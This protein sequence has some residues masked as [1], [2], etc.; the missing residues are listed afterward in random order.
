M[1]VTGAGWRLE[2]LHLPGH[3]ADHLGFALDR[4][5][6]CGDLVMGWSTS[7]ISPPDGDLAAFMA[8]LDRLKTRDWQVLLPGHGAPVD[9]PSDRIQALI[10][11]RQARADAVHAALARAPA[12]AETLAKAIYTDTPPALLPAAARNVLAQLIAFHEAG[13]ARFD[14]PLHAGSVFRLT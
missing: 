10:A 3:M 2:A 11:H 6:F 4:T 14:G 1:A 7:L 5:L 12:D 8:S 9:A 13:I